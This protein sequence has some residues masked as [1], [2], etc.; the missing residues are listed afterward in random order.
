MTFAYVVALSIIA[1]LSIASYFTLRKVISGQEMSASVINVTN[2]QRFL[3]QNVAIYSLCLANAEDASE[4]ETLK[5]ELLTT[6][7]EMERAHKGLV[8]SDVSLKLP[9]RQS[10][11]VKAFYFELPVL[12]DK[13]MYNYFAEAVAL[14]K[15]PA[16]E[17]SPHNI[18]V[19]NILNELA[20]DLVESLDVVIN[21]LQGESEKSNRNLQ[22]LEFAVLCVT[23]LALLAVAWYIFRPMVAR[24]ARDMNEQ[25]RAQRRTDVQ[26]AV[27]KVLADS[28]DVEKTV[29]LLLQSLGET[30]NYNVGLFWVREGKNSSLS[31][32]GTWQNYSPTKD[33]E[34]LFSSLISL[35]PENALPE[36]VSAS[37][38]PIGIP[39]MAMGTHVCHQPVAKKYN[40][41][42]AV[43]FPV[44]SDKDALGVFEFF[45]IEKQPVDTY[46]LDCLSTLGNHIGQFFKRKES[47]EQI[48]HLATHDT[49]T[50]LFN[51]RRFNEE[52]ANW[53]TQSRRY[54][55]QG[56]LLFVD[57][58]NFK[59]VNDT[60]G[61]KTGDDLLV[62]ITTV[63]KQRLR[64]SDVL[65][66]LG[67]DEFAALLYHVNREQAEH[68]TQQM[69]ETVSQNGRYTNGQRTNVTASIG[70]ALFPEHSEELDALIACADQAMYRA[71]EG[72]R[73]CFRMYDKNA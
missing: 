59:Y 42:G 32:K 49:L 20:S 71:K 58:D 34:E 8:Y 13:K 18:H 28:H 24:M 65:A 30:L 22:W 43:A 17:L 57:L 39:D 54:G 41:H 66:R 60:Y 53:L 70:I 29:Q 4:I 62:N 56:A 61:H 50:N 11:R 7:I 46:L 12:L 72:G 15:E 44:V 3:T 63:L 35:S 6:V 33:P 16:T 23:L 31:C 51:R 10:P 9:G 67:G 45:S 37:N 25:K 14:S 38:S 2:R 26:Y 48:T 36:L 1:L 19:S 69:V 55:T 40:L 27:T 52:L 73:N 68:I 64:K 21:Q 5:Q 47:E